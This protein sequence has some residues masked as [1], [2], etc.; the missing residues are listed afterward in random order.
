MSAGH[1][2][3]SRVQIDSKTDPPGGFRRDQCSPGSHEGFKHRLAGAGVVQHR[4]AHALDRLLR[5]MHRG[6]ILVLAGDVPQRGL[7]AVASPMALAGLLDRIPARFMLP[8]IIALAED[9]PVLGPDYLR[10]D[11]ETGRHQALGD[12]RGMQ[13][14]M[15]NISSGRYFSMI[16][17]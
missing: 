17:G 3:V 13:G 5:A 15:P 16:K 14:A 1:I 8:V 11:G 7:L 4:A 10:P 12:S 9:K 6:G 2:D